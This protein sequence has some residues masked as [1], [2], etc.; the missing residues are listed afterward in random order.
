MATKK[1]K[2]TV[3]GINVDEVIEEIRKAVPCNRTSL[4]EIALYKFLKGRSIREIAG[5]VQQYRKSAS[6]SQISDKVI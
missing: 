3:N 4:K 2:Y 6:I 5:D 1:T